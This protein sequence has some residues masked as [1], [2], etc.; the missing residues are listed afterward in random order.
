[1]LLVYIPL[2]VIA[3][4]ASTVSGLK[5][6]VPSG[7]VPTWE[8]PAARTLDAST[9]KAIDDA[10]LGMIRSGKAVGLVIGVVDDDKSA[11]LGYGRRTLGSD[12]PPDADTVFEIGSV[13]K[14]FTALSLAI[15]AERGL[16]KLD[17]PVSKYLPSSVHV[18]AYKGRHITLA[19]LATHTSGLPEEPGTTQGSE[20]DPYAHF[21]TAEM[22]RF[23]NAHKLTRAPG[24]KYEYSNMGMGLVGL[25]LSRRLGMPYE[26]MV[27]TLICRPLG[28]RDTVITLFGDQKSRLATGYV[29][30]RRVGSLDLA[31]PSSPWTSYES[32]A[33]AGDIRSTGNDMLRYLKA[34]MGLGPNAKPLP[35]ELVQKR[36]H[37]AGGDVWIG[38]GWH[39]LGRDSTDGTVWHNGESGG[40]YSFIAFS[41]KHRKGLV[42]LSNSTED[43]DAIDSLGFKLLDSMLKNK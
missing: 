36:R 19:D 8:S 11:V 15:M 41:R 40:Y 13:T 3:F 32:L 23:L 27:N 20:E 31:Q 24:A 21:D 10:A 33:G 39:G 4:I 29:R 43:G 34:N 6:G 14:T 37:D 35:F 17:D 25:V 28:M 18:P 42:I 9:R 1:M 22:Y 38:L 16:V 2:L 7:K 12:V 30:Q 26:K 5:V